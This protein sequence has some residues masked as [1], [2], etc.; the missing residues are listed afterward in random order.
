MNDFDSRDVVRALVSRIKNAR[1]TAERFRRSGYYESSEMWD[2]V[3]GV[4]EGV[5]YDANL[6]G[7]IRQINEG[8]I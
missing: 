6:H 4:L 8:E 1:N 2:T 5:L 7:I 3:A